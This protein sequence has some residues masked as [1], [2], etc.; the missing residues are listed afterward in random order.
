NDLCQKAIQQGLR[1]LI[2]ADVYVRHTGE[3]SF[4]GATRKAR[5]KALRE[6]ALQFPD[7]ERDVAHFVARDPVAAARR[8][9][10]LA[11]LTRAA[12]GP[13]PV[14][15]I[16][17]SRGGGVER[18]IRDSI[19]ALRKAGTGA[20]LLRSVQGRPG[21]LTLNTIEDLYLPNL[22]PVSRDGAVDGLAGILREAG[23]SH[24]E[25]HNL[26][27]Y[28]Q[29]ADRRVGDLAKA[30]GVTYGFTVHDYLSVCPR[31]NLIDSSGIYCGESGADACRVCLASGEALPDGRPDITA[32]RDGYATLLSGA[33]S[34]RAPSHDAARRIEGYFPGLSVSVHPH[35]ERIW[36]PADY[37]LSVHQPGEPVRVAVIGAIGPHKGSA[38]LLECARDALKRELPLQ[39]VIVGYSDRHELEKLANVTVTGRYFEQ[40]V[41]DLIA[42][43]GCHVAFLPSVVPE[44][45]SY[46]L[47]IAQAAGL[48]V[49]AFDLG[50]IAERLPKDGK[51]WLVPWDLVKQPRKL[52]DGL[53]AF[54]SGRDVG[55]DWPHADEGQGLRMACKAGTA[56]DETNLGIQNQ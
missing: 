34:V 8:S 33:A 28:P 43:H 48:P 11:R 46:T 18:H 32:W 25:V 17:H 37:R 12:G 6:L 38:V 10:D 24:I 13:D 26:A 7:Y 50:A 19:R 31:I 23:V 5:T 45:Y 9:L 36:P 40:E 54:G 52:A 4:G 49:A 21:E 35:E 1:N 44:T 14:L 3:V 55:G 56:T 51:D 27:D 53:V 39:F 29:D 42:R 16:S 20:I 47:S 41:F 30:L 15:F 22:N 2:A